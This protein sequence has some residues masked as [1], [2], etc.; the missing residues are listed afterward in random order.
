MKLTLNEIS[1]INLYEKISNSKV[2]D[3]IIEEK[4]IFVV[5]DEN[6]GKVILSLIGKSC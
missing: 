2:K 6:I 4:I 1:F 3:C 5:D